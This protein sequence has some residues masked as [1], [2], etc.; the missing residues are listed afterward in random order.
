VAVTVVDI[1]MAKAV[2]MAA[3]STITSMVTAVAADIVIKMEDVRWKKEDEY[4]WKYIQADD[5]W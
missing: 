3:A 2:K 4:V 5:V 1:I